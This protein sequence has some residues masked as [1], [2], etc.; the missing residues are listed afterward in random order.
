MTVPILLLAEDDPDDRE[1]FCSGMHRIFPNAIVNPFEKSDEL[2]T[3]LDRCAAAGL[4]HCIVLDYKMYPHNA[5]QILMET[6]PGTRYAHIP[7]VV[8]STSERDEEREECLRLGATRFIVKPVSDE[9]L[10][11]LLR[12]FSHWLDTSGRPLTP[13]TPS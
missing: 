2:L 10:D 5:P 11:S 12:S 1:F 4:P 13:R 8:W 7:R 9:Q 3:Y 6:G